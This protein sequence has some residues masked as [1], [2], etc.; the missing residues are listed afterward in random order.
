MSHD[1]FSMFHKVQTAQDLPTKEKKQ[2]C[3]NHLNPLEGRR[4]PVVVSADKRG[5][6]TKNLGMFGCIN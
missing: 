6:I 4:I 2:N 3:G 5:W 1:I